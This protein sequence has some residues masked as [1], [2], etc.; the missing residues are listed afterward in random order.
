MEY[1]IIDQVWMDDHDIC[2]H[3]GEL[4]SIFY[5]DQHICKTN[6]THMKKEIP[7]LFSTPMVQAI[8]AGRKTMTRR[9]VKFP[10][11]FDGTE[12]YKNGHFGLKYSSS[13]FG[14]TV[15]RLLPPWAVGSILWVRE[16]WQPYLRGEGENGYVELI[17]FTADG[18]EFP[19]KHNKD[20]S[21]LGW[22]SRPSIHLPK[23]AARIW[24]EID[25]IKVERLHDI[26]VYD[27]GDEGVEYWNVDHE[28][29]EGGEFVADYS[30]YEWRDDPKYEDYYFPTYAN[31]IDSFFSLW[32]KINGKESF[33]SNPWV[34]VV[35][36]KVL[37]TTGKP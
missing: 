27:A 4:V 37:S 3:C 6:T 33:L 18:S 20:Y 19:F 13:H 26:T 11:D 5:P 14:G 15:Q 10:K 1:S 21:E 25:S 17:R 36:F 30:N 2:S 22:H 9:T 35:S 12:V 7:I 34:W 31:P 29:L 23:S 24:L 28:A 16:T 32:R 8:L